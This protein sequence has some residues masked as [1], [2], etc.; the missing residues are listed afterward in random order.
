MS[1]HLHV[2]VPVAMTSNKMES[3]HV[4]GYNSIIS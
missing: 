2:H 1:V 4:G 3:P